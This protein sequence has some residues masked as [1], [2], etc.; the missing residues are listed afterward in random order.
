MEATSKEYLQPQYRLSEVVKFTPNA[1]TSLSLING[2]KVNIQVPV[3]QKPLV[4]TYMMYNIETYMM[5]S[6]I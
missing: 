5:Y 2:T 1:P 4:Y 6:H 3:R